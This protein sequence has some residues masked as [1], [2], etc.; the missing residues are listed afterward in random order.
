MLNYLFWIFFFFKGLIGASGY[1]LFPLYIWGKPLEYEDPGVKQ[2][3]APILIFNAFLG[4]V[5]LL[6][7][8]LEILGVD[9]PIEL[10]RPLIP[11]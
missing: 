10:E 2:I 1:T 11:V 4:E 8:G 7:P 9:N 3:F 5:L 6:I